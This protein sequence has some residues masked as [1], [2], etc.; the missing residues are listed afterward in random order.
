MDRDVVGGGIID[1]EEDDAGAGIEDNLLDL[2]G[3]FSASVAGERA[4]EGLDD[5]EEENILE[6][7]VPLGNRYQI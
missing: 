5:D 7:M 1:L 2:I 3:N 4:L 6:A